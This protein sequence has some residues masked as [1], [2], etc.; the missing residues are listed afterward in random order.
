[1]NTDFS[2][3]KKAALPVQ[4]TGTGQLFI[5]Q[6]HLFFV[7]AFGMTDSLQACK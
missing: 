6:Q 2:E 5:V 3:H 4:M 1:M 7:N